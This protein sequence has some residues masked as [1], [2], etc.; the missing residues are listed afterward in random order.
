MS[1]LPEAVLL[2]LLRQLAAG[3]TLAPEQLAARCAVSQSA[4]SAE[5]PRLV[6]HGV[7]QRRDGGLRIPGGLRLLEAQTIATMVATAGIVAPQVEVHG[8][9]G[10]TNDLARKRVDSGQ[11]GAASI[12]A[13]A[14]TAGRGRRGRSWSSPVAS[15]IYL[16]HIE[17]LLGGLE[18]SRGLS[19][20]VGV[21]VAEAIEQ[22]SGVA[23]QLK[24]P[25][26]LLAQGRKL[27]GILVELLSHGAG[28][29]AVLGIGINVQLPKYTGRSIDQ[30]WIDLREAAGMDID[31]NA[32]S[33]ALIVELSRQ[34]QYFRERGFDADLRRR[35]QQ[36]DPFRDRRVIASSEQG[37]WRGWAR[38][39]DGN[40]EFCIETDSG[41]VAVGAGEVSL[42]LE[43][44]A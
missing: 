31:R 44:S 10:S 12:L 37:S 26:D 14:Q 34:V 5:L 33:A 41:L 19:L 15:N 32:L 16:S 21:A 30:P 7:R 9:I 38:G 22:F 6:E 35:W 11:H 23:V 43:E 4:I 17:P 36:R 1:E 24:W 40:G 3:E 39:I 27:G 18:A 28:C 25:N 29:H 20:V 2:D 8:V 42:R 13:E